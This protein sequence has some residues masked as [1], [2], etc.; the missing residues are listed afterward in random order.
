MSYKL[1]KLKKAQT[2]LFRL[3]WAFYGI[4]RPS[5]ALG[6]P[7]YKNGMIAVSSTEISKII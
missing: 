7:L 5:A 6:I 3:T 1:I 4:L 2:N